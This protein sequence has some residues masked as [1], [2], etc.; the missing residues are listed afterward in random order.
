MKRIKGRGFAMPI[1]T[2]KKTQ[3]K[4]IYKPVDSKIEIASEQ[5][6]RKFFES[7][8]ITLGDS[9]GTCLE[10]EFPEWKPMFKIGVSTYGCKK[11]RK[12]HK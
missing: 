8:S 5:V 2:A 4:Q 7:G 6:Q 3:K 10:V 9:I 11:K 12:Q 1:M